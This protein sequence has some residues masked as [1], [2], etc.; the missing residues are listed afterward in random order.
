MDY[1]PLIYIVVWLFWG[2]VGRFSE[3]LN[4]PF[5]KNKPEKL[6]IHQMELYKY[7]EEKIKTIGIIPFQRLNWESARL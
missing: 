3:R 1:F 2:W 4:H 6:I 7:H 5:S